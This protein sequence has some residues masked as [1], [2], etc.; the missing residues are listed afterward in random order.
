[1]DGWATEEE[2]MEEGAA[3]EAAEMGRKPGWE[4]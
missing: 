2:K 4:S 3:R 1:M